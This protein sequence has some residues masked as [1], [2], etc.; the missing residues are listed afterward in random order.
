MSD[1]KVLDLIW[2][3]DTTDFARSGCAPE[4]CPQD[5]DQ[6]AIS[7]RLLEDHLVRRHRAFSGY[8]RSS[9]SLK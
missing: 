9:R 5:Q 6:D 1:G 3:F 4:L 7:R 8:F 2:R